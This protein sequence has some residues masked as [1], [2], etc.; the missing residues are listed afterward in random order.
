MGGYRCG[1]RLVDLKG[2]GGRDMK[3]SGRLCDEIPRAFEEGWE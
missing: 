1:V 2:L 3:E